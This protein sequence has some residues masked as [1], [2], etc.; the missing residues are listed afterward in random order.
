[1]NLAVVG[2]QW[3]D[4]GKGKIVDLLAPRF[5]VTVRYQGGPNAGHTVVFDGRTHALHHIPSGIFHEG[6]RCLVGPGTLIDPDRILAEIDGLQAGGL[7]LAHRLG[8]SA[9]AH[10]ILPV[11]LLLDS[12]SEDDLGSSA[13][14][15]TRRGIGPAY[16]SKAERWGVRLGDLGHRKCVEERFERA[17]RCGLGERLRAMGEAE[18]DPSD[19]A[20]RAAEWWQRLEVY[21]TDVV[22]EVH[23]ALDAQQPILFEGAQGALLDIEH[24]TYPF[25]TSSSTLVGGIC[26]SLGIPP[27]AVDHALGIFKAYATRVG[28]GPFPSEEMGQAGAALRENGKEFGTT[29]GRPRRCGWFDAVAARHAV[30]LNGLDAMVVTK[31]D[32][33]AGFEAVRIAVAYEIDGERTTT[34]PATTTALARARP[35]FED[36]PGWE[37]ASAG[38]SLDDIPANGR[39]YLDRLS[40]LC[41]CPVAMLSVG[42]S[43]EETIFMPDGMLT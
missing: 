2:A 16:A 35:I 29:T 43:R 8:L 4:E 41:R 30:R 15:T 22:S 28:A 6:V 31:F 32:V 25:V 38:A 10:V 36:F 40:E 19:I 34:F 33:L 23:D 13:I 3:G 14:G 26:P 39:K 7:D 24:G 20:D 18:P 27:K 37:I 42:P 5:A 21:T 17:L 1:M 9:R 12:A 11:H